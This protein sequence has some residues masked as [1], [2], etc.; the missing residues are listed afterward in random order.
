MDKL[1][2]RYWISGHMHIFFKST[3]KYPNSKETTFFAADKAQDD[4]R[5]FVEVKC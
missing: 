4:W 3:V 5:H 1:Q 2:P